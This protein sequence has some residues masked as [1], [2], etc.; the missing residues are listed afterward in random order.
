MERHPPLRVENQRFMA[1]FQASH[2]QLTAR[3]A[4]VNQ[5]TKRSKD[6]LSTRVLQFQMTVIR[7]GI[8]QEE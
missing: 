2:R 6:Q 5:L 3:R 1:V 7:N 8:E 4:A